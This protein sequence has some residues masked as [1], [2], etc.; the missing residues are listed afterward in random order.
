[1][2]S[3]QTVGRPWVCRLSL[4]QSHSMLCLCQY[5]WHSQWHGQLCFRSTSGNLFP[6]LWIKYSLQHLIDAWFMFRLNNFACKRILVCFVIVD[7]VGST[8]QG[9]P[10]RVCWECVCVCVS[11]SLPLTPSWLSTGAIRNRQKRPLKQEKDSLHWSSLKSLCV[12]VCA[13]VCLC[14]YVCVSDLASH[15]LKAV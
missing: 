4:R 6:N 14:L 3:V 2:V 1:M 7:V 12:C 10:Q 8:N 5:V 13:F 9:L 11:V 15:I